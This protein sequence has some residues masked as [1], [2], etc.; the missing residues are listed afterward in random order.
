M[1]LNLNIAFFLTFAFLHCVSTFGQAG[2][3]D[4]AVREQM[5]KR[6]IAGA[7]VAV[8][9]NGESVFKKGYGLA[10]V[11]RSIP[12]APNTKYQIG[13]TTKPLTAMAMMMLVEEGKISLDEKA[14]KYLSKLPVQ[15]GDITV[16]QLLTH[17]SG[18][19]RDLRT[20]NTDDFT[21]EEFWKRLAA[22][23]AS[24][25]PGERWEYSNTGYI[26]LTMLIE[27][28]TG[29]TYGEFLQKRIFKPLGMKDTAYL[30]PFGKNKNRA[31]GYDWLENAFRPSPY[32]S[33]G[34]GAGGLVS[35]VSDLAKWDAALDSVKLLKQS[36]LE[37]MLTPARLADGKTVSFDF[38]GEPASYGF[39][40]FL[41]RYRGHRVITH[42]GVISGFSSQIVRFPDDGISI[43]VNANGKS[44]ADRIGYAEHLSKIIADAFVPGLS[45]ASAAR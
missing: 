37:Q 22:A 38:R 4:E 33:G 39:G 28:V 40:W 3:I 15:Y 20:G 13:S 2:K 12:A 16:R 25:K 11:E 8:L 41:T 44:G 19:N 14:A 10:N 27:S 18:V 5:A 7:S 23:P 42:G 45:P 32:F 17:T 36:S 35:T 26:I 34:F 21:A 43:V 1:S 9:R 24:F 6:H 31:V 29:K 30:E